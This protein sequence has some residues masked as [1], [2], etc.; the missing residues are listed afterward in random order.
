MKRLALTGLLAALAAV[1]RA[2]DVPSAIA[3]EISQKFVTAC[4]GGKVSEALALYT[5]DAVVVYPSEGASA[6]GKV[7]LA[8][9]LGDLCEEGLGKSKWL[10]GSGAWL[11]PGENTIIATGAWETAGVD[12]DGKPVSVIVRTTEVLVKTPD[13]WK[14]KLDHASV[15]VPLPAPGPEKSSSR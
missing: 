1:A 6:D 4:E 15:G 7:E 2:G 5:D 14:Y 8:K 11:G 13:G 10:G 3:H 9:V 12:A